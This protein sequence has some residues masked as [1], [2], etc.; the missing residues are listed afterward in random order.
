MSNLD[1]SIAFTALLEWP[2]FGALEMRVGERVITELVAIYRADTKITMWDAYLAY[3]A[4]HEGH[5]AE[6]AAGLVAP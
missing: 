6:H 1:R 5:L 4:K 2:E 3:R